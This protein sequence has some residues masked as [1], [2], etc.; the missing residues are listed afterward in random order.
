[1]AKLSKSAQWMLDHPTDQPC[2]TP[3]SGM[4]AQ[5]WRIKRGIGGL[6]PRGRSSRR[7]GARL[8]GNHSRE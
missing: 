5:A 2:P 8:N 4:A 6:R 1:M 3:L 7:N